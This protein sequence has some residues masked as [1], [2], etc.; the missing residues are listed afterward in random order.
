MGLNLHDGADRQTRVDRMIEEFRAAQSRRFG[1]PAAP[2][3]ES[4]A[5]PNAK[6][7]LT[8]SAISQ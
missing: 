4:K 5:D 2:A 8:E 6:T 1:K 7:S 3:V